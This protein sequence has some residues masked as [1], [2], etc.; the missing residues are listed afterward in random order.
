MKLPTF[1]PILAA[2]ASQ[3]Q[4]QKE[5][6]IF[7]GW[8]EPSE[9]ANQCSE[10]V[11]ELGG[12]FETSNEGSHGAII[13]NDY[14]ANVNCKHVVEAR[15]DCGEIKIQYRSVAVVDFLADVHPVQSYYCR[16]S[17]FFR[18]GWPKPNSF[19]VT[20]ASCGCFGDGCDTLKNYF[21]DNLIDTFAGH[22]DPG[23]VSV[24]SNTFTFY[25]KSGPARN[26]NFR[27]V[28]DWECVKDAAAP[29]ITTTT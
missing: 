4:N 25:F 8:F 6:E 13:L 21:T 18:F 3:Q 12:V 11:P 10:Q 1:L 23:S 7:I 29:T 2:V 20:P 24:D 9:V 16:Y 5:R 22:S 14:P 27:V 19:H 15:S 28:L 17:D 26:S